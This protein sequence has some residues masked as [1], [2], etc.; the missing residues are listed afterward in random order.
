[1]NHEAQ[2]QHK[3]NIVYTSG[4]YNYPEQVTLNVINNVADDGEHIA[5]VDVGTQA[6]ALNAITILDKALSSI[7]SSQAKLGSIQ[8]RSSTTLTT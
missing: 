4:D 7:T 6:G 2:Q 5:N 3:F 8:N 1:M